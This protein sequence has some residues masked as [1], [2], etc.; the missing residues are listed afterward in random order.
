MKSKP[1]AKRIN[2]QDNSDKIRF[3]QANYRAL[4][5]CQTPASSTELSRLVQDAAAIRPHQP[6]HV[7]LPMAQYIS[8]MTDF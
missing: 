6:R 2:Y 4:G 1:L 5:N 8:H 7:S 3:L